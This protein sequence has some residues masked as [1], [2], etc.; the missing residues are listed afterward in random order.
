MISL[1]LD[2]SSADGVNAYVDRVKQRIFERLHVG[3]QEEMT[4]LA[5]A[6]L[7]QMPQAGIVSRTGKL[8]T[9]IQS[10]PS[11][12]E[13][14]EV[15]RGTVSA[16]VGKKHLGLWFQEGTHVKAVAGKLYGFTAPD[17]NTVFTRGHKA[18]DVKPHP[19]LNPALDRMRQQIF[20]RLQ[21]DVN[22]ALAG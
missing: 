12:E 22:E 2:Q 18:F 11:V 5:G 6:V 20:N 15:I 16:D 13:T 1:V 3:M 10:S 19:I 14:S 4:E 7:A 17:G 9:A 8:A 21:Q